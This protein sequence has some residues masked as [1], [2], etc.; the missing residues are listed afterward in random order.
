MPSPGWGFRFITVLTLT[1]GTAFVMWLG[2]QITERGVGNGISL[3]IFGGIVVGL[4]GAIFATVGSWQ[5][6]YILHAVNC[7]GAPVIRWDTNAVDGLGLSRSQLQR[8]LVHF[9]TLD[10]IVQPFVH[11]ERVVAELVL[12]P[13]RARAARVRSRRHSHS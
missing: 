6:L 3:I 5:T 4:P 13:V 10:Q 12:R 1:T 7:I 9:H 8:D 2:E 11:R